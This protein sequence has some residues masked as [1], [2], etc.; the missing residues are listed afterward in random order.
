MSDPLTRNKTYR[1]PSSLVM[2]RCFFQPREC[3]DEYTRMDLESWKIGTVRVR[4]CKITASHEYNGTTRESLRETL[5]GCLRSHGSI[6][7]I[8]HDLRVDLQI[9]GIFELIEAGHVAIEWLMLAPRLVGVLKWCGIRVKLMDIA[10]WCGVTMHAASRW[11]DYSPQG[12][13]RSKRGSEL[14]MYTLCR[15][16]KEWITWA[17][18]YNH[19]IISPTI[20][21]TSFDLWRQFYAPTDT[22]TVPMSGGEPFLLPCFGQDSG[23][24]AIHDDALVQPP[25][26]LKKT[27]TVRGPVY[28]LDVKAFYPSL[29]LGKRQP[30]KLVASGDKCDLHGLKQL[31]RNYWVCAKVKLTQSK[32]KVPV[33]VNGRV[34]WQ[35]PP[36]ETIAAGIELAYYVESGSVSGLK[37]FAAYETA[38]YLSDFGY[39]MIKARDAAEKAA[40]PAHAAFTKKI[41]NA[42]WGRFAPRRE[43]WDTI[44]NAPALVPWGE[45]YHKNNET[46][47]STKRRSIGN[48]VQEQTFKPWGKKSWPAAAAFICA[49]A[50]FAINT[51]CDGVG[52]SNV[53]YRVVD[54][55]H[56]TQEGF[57][58]LSDRITWDNS[59]PG[60]LRIAGVYDSVTYHGIY[61]WEH[62]E[63]W[64]IAG[65][66]RNAVKLG[67]GKYSG[68]LLTGPAESYQLGD[69]NSVFARFRVFDYGKHPAKG[70]QY[71]SE[72]LRGRNDGTD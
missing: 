25:V 38:D 70:E 14:E 44:P 52:D 16:A 46:G 3:F 21:K 65:L 35:Y 53:I 45:W 23:R 57:N 69:L 40:N 24:N 15:L 47:E 17:E 39:A 61:S 43:R 60:Q 8:G 12:E 63:G 29:Y 37:W 55:L 9:G 19:G 66:P 36:C 30:S 54:G 26:Q 10:A 13:E 28:D 50:R 68:V 18:T 27:G 33:Y 62:G 51:L 34:Q 48:V 71:A 1:S 5:E 6:I 59:T 64:S 22:Q 2:L 32:W 7:L 31:L 72:H 4:R 56:V 49:E 11:F 67:D 20:G 41:A 42:L 58:L